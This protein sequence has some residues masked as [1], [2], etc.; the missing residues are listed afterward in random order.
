MTSCEH[1]N[2]AGRRE[3]LKAAAQ[4]AAVPLLGR[5]ADGSAEPTSRSRRPNI[6]LLMADQ[7]R[8]DC[9]GCDGNKVVR[10]PNLDRL[11]QEGARFST[12]YSSTPTCTPARTALLTGLSPWHHGMLGMTR[13]STRYPVKLPQALRDAG[14]Y[15]FGIGKMHFHPQ[16]ALNGFHGT[17]LDE[18]GRRETPDFISDY[19]QWFAKQAPGKD[20]N[21]TGIGWNDH[22]ARVYAL[23]EELHPTHWTGQM[24]VDFLTTYDRPEPFF[25][26]VSFARPHSPYDPPARFME[27]YKEQDMPA[28]HL[29]D[30][31]RRYAPVQQPFTNDLWHGDLG[32]DQVRR[33]RRGYYGS[34]T[35]VD[36]QI[37]RIITALGRRGML[38]NTFILYTADH[39]DMTGDHHLWRKSY[40][41]EASARIPY[42][43]RWPKG[44]APDSQ[45]AKAFTQPVELRDVLPTFMDVAGVSIPRHL[46]GRSVLPLLRGRTEGWRPFIDLEHDICYDKENHWNALT[47][48]HW[49]YIFHAFDGSEQLFDLRS[50]PGETH[51]V[52]TE[53]AHKSE[54]GTWRQRMVRHLSERGERFV[55]EGR[56]VRRP[57]RMLTSPNFPGYE[58]DRSRS[59]Q[60]G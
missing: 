59:G 46:D 12:A 14:Y 34:V 47:D 28:P 18:S 60:P 31:A 16:R 43:V 35:F 17:L 51:D 25:L 20:P 30:W 11:A 50:D 49:K 40:A 10:T 2:C 37:G 54:L 22:R 33:S 42:L 44:M 19:H 5:Y 38:D 36:E 48:G 29:G 4:I 57:E 32:P 21:A 1:G 52:A 13:M 8:G 45:R 56:L 15:T 23:P 55:K 53:P 39:G 3:F 41:Y 9:L 27:M 58:P 6:L 7:H 26:K 24:A